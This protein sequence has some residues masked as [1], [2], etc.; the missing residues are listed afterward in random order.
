LG[1]IYAVILAQ[2]KKILK[3]SPDNRFALLLA[4]FKKLPSF[5]KKTKQKKNLLIILT[6][7]GETGLPETLAVVLKGKVDKR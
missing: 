5:K 3:P 7:G 6:S 1:C 4:M 2:K